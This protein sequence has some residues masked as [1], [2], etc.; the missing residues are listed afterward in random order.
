MRYFV[1]Q[2]FR[3]TAGKRVRDPSWVPCPIRAG[4]AVS[5]IAQCLR[6]STPNVRDYSSRGERPFRNPKCFSP[7]HSMH[8]T[9]IFV[10]NACAERLPLDILAAEFGWSVESVKSL[11]ELREV[12][13]ERHIIAVLFDAQTLR[14]EPLCAL[15]AIQD[16]APKALPIVC[17]RSSELIRWPELA[18]AGAFHALLLPFHAGEIRQSLAFVHERQARRGSR[19]ISLPRVRAAYRRA[20]PSAVVA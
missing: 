3:Q 8:G 15:E 10:G 14:L 17:H 20:L 7:S 13:H 18:D 4:F 6:G 12:R 1:Q 16:A 11:D 19:V 9:L 5:E 2:L